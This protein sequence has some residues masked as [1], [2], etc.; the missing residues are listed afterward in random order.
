MK[1][2]SFFKLM[3]SSAAAAALF[4]AVARASALPPKQKWRSYQLTYQVTLPASG[5]VAKLWLPLPDASD[6]SYQFTQGNNWSGKATAT[7]FYML[8]GTQSQV[9]F[10]LWQKGEERTVRVSS[11]IKTAD[12]TVDLSS[13]R[14]PANVSIPQNIK[15]Y[16][17]PTKYIPLDNAI[18]KMAQT[19]TSQANAHTPLQQARTIYDW[20]IDNV[21]YDTSGRGQGSGD[22]RSL[23]SRKEN[24]SGRCVDIHA[25]FVGLARA[26]GIPARI[27]YGIRISDSVLNKNL[28]KSGDISTSQHS[29]AEFYLAGLGWVPVNPSDVARVMAAE[30]LLHHHDSISQ[31]REKL[32]GS[33]E[34][35]WVAF[36]E[37]ENVDLGTTKASAAINKLPFFSYP[38]AEIDGRLQ[39][40]LEPESF[41][42]KIT[43]AI[44]VGTGAKL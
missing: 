24:F 23:L 35:N 10:A 43:S 31:L 20:V 14:V 44:L 41:S 12:R 15:R 7:A 1:R 6:T 17:Q 36:N 42:Y 34:M 2:R 27:Q 13:Y 33:W 22:L 37:K 3:G 4:P 32:F 5:K 28:G 26:S 40:S 29:Q 11:I 38:Y 9:F 25:L 8:P 18:K 16:L 30:S 21:A 19:I 39:D